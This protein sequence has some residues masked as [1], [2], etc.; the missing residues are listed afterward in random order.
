MLY[1][2]HFKS[3]KP[4]DQQNTLRGLYLGSWFEEINYY[5]GSNGGRWLMSM[6]LVAFSHLSGMEDWEVAQNFQPSSPSLQG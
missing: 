1:L 4:K 5:S 3:L 2:L 6:G